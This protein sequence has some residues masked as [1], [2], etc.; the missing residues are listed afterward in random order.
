[1][2]QVSN[3]QLPANCKFLG[4]YFDEYLTFWTHINRASTKINFFVMMLKHLT[5]FWIQRLWSMYMYIIRL[6]TLIF[7]IGWNSGGNSCKGTLLQILVCQKKALRVNF[8]KPSNSKYLKSCLLSFFL[9]FARLFLCVIYSEIMKIHWMNW[10]LI[11]ILILAQKLK[12][13]TLKSLKLLKIKTEKGR[14]SV[15][16]SSVNLVSSHAPDIIDFLPTAFRGGALAARPWEK[17]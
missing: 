7:Y 10:Q 9:D 13:E 8:K 6:Y 15:L 3:V 11:T 1:M 12:S 4:I 5:K 17:D 16:Y 2:V 14:R